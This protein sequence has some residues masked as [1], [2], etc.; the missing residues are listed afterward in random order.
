MLSILAKLLIISFQYNIESV[1]LFYTHPVYGSYL[2][3][4]GVYCDRFL[5]LLLSASK[6][7]TAIEH[8]IMTCP[9]TSRTCAKNF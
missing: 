1:C 8:Q 9:F 2:F 4:D 6:G 5:L 3:P 7:N